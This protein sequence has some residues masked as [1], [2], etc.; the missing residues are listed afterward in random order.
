MRVVDHRCKGSLLQLLEPRGAD[1]QDNG[2]DR[3]LSL[4]DP[5]G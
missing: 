3:L 4:R 1:R 2:Q 5:N